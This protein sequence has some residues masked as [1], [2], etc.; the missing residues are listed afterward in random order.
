[1]LCDYFCRS[2]Y[3]PSIAFPNGVFDAEV[4][5]QLEGKGDQYGL[6]VASRCILRTEEEAH[7]YGCRGAKTKNE[8][9]EAEHIGEDLDP[10]RYPKYY[11]GF[12]DLR[13]A[14]IQKVA[15]R[16]EYY[17]MVLRWV[18]E[19]DEMAHFE[20]QL[21]EPVTSPGPKKLKN[22]RKWARELLALCLVGPYPHLCDGDERPD[23]VD[24]VRLPP[25]VE[26]TMVQRDTVR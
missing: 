25:C 19:N 26:Q 7:Q 9:Y 2:V 12:Y 4:L 18:P 20:I 24:A 10:A 8:R 22:D 15:Y 13:V 11:M 5:V 6:S 16:L 1:M 21:H 17:R 23:G 14:A 3:F